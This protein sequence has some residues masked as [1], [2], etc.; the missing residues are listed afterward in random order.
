[1]NKGKAILVVGSSGQLGRSIQSIAKHFPEYKF[2][3]VSRSDINL[4]SKASITKFFERK[5]FD[6]IINCAAHTGVDIAESEAELAHQINHFAV[7]QLAKIAK[8]DHAKLI[9]ISTDYVFSGKQSQP[10]TE[11]DEVCPLTVYGQ[12]KLEGELAIKK[13]LNTNAVIIRTSW[14]YSEYGD[15]FLKTMIRLG[16]SR[17]DLNVVFDQVGTPTYAKDLAMAIMS[18]I[19]SQEFNL[20]DFKTDVVH[21]S[22][23]GVCSWYDFA[24]T[25]FELTDIRCQITPV[26]SIDYPVPAARPHFSVLNKAK[27]K[28]KYKVS[29]P[30]WKD[31]A[32]RCVTALEE[33]K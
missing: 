29:I 19:Q 3:F 11:T 27:I 25:I 17:D 14:L 12:T 1:M 30:Y 6:I 15:N 23:E 20:I 16:Q 28:L 21:F 9:Q 18:V 10:Y 2:V 22:N 4:E 31:S 13:I 7:E 32:T 8:R 26:E 5:T 33:K 24:K